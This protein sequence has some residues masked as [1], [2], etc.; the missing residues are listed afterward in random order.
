M[1]IVKLIMH[2]YIYMTDVKIYNLV[3]T[4]FA[5]LCKI[6]LYESNPTKMFLPDAHKQAGVM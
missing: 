5:S 3:A 2:I 4:K 1:L 6:V